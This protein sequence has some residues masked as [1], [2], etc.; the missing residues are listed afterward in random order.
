MARKSRTQRH[1][2]E[3]TRAK[4]VLL[5][6]TGGIAAY[7]ACEIVRRLAEHG[8]TVQVVMTEAAA[9]FISPLTLATL[10]GRPVWTDEF[11]QGIG[12]PASAQDVIAHI[13]L[14]EQADVFVVAPA[15]ANTIAKIAHGIADNLLTSTALAWRGPALVAPAMNH[16]MYENPATQEN[17]Q[18]LSQLG[19]T[20][21]EPEEGWLACGETGR[22]RLASIG[23][24]VSSVLTAI[25]ERE[26]RLSGKRIVVT[27]GGT[28]EPLDPVRF[29]SNASTGVLALKCA[30]ALAAEGAHIDLIC[31]SGVS[32]E[33]LEEVPADIAHVKTA[34][35]IKSAVEKKVEDCDALLMLAAVA[36]YAPAPATHKI[37]KDEQE[38]LNLK[39]QR[40]E[41][42]LWSLRERHDF[43]KI[44]V[45]LET[46]DA[47]ARAGAKLQDKGLDAIV[48]VDYR[49]EETPFGDV[50]IRAAVLTGEGER[51]PLELRAK[52]ELAGEIAH[53]TAI[54]LDNKE[55]QR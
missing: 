29:I 34:A 19:Y 50:S 41:D 45:S 6:V 25:R 12:T 51:L 53:L 5:G 1:K 32:S 37:K 52:T 46:E 48:A 8:L 55:K 21:I 3:A 7:K 23:R 18:T 15:T 26:G 40:T 13:D 44:G 42:I 11:P 33:L 4:T 20:E 31:G 30:S 38:T 43:I 14:A 10:S 27:V 22:G 39:L 2:L 16:R 24:I 35:E 36:D 47:L 17:L 28:R 54:L 49:A 9:R